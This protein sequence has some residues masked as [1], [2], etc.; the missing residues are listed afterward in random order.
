[1]ADIPLQTDIWWPRTVLH[2][3][4][5]THNLLIS[6]CAVGEVSHTF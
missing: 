5:F 4:S 6:I 2:K 1:M 3:D